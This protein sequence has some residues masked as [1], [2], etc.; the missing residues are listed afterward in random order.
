MALAPAALPYVAA[1]RHGG[2]SHRIGLTGRPSLL[3]AGLVLTSWAVDAWDVAHAIAVTEPGRAGAAT[4]SFLQAGVLLAAAVAPAA[5]AAVVAARCRVRRV[6]RLLLVPALLL[7]LA[8]LA[9]LVD[10]YF[11]TMGA[12][13]RRPSLLDLLGGASTVNWAATLLLVAVAV[14]AGRAQRRARDTGAARAT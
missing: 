2:P 1:S 4:G 14:G 6:T 13:P 3:P 7:L 10:Q 9:G 12:A 5:V 11:D 8:S